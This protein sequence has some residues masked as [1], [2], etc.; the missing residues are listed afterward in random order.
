MSFLEPWILLGLA[1]GLFQALRVAGQRALA[2]RT[3]AQVQL[4][5]WSAALAR[6][7]FGLP[8][9]VLILV[10]LI[11]IWGPPVGFSGL[12]P[13]AHPGPNPNLSLDPGL[14]S[15]R[16]LG[17]PTD[18]WLWTLGAALLQI[19]ATLQ[20]TLLLSQ[21]TFAIGVVYVKTEVVIVALV[22]STPFFAQYLSGLQWAAVLVSVIG[23]VVLTRARLPGEIG[24]VWDLRS[25]WLGLSGGALLAGTSLTLREAGLI[26]VAEGVVVAQP[27]SPAVAGMTTLV[28]LL[29]IQCIVVIGVM[30]L[31]DASEFA[32]V[33]RR[34]PPMAF[35][36]F[37]SALGSAGWFIG[38]V[39]AAPALVKS[40]GQV[41]F[42]AA[43]VLTFVFF[44]ERP[45][46]TEW[47]GMGI[48]LISILMLLLSTL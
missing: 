28:A 31:R 16:L 1:A 42:I 9:A 22:G 2:Q 48:I 27:V 24:S 15:V 12:G 35:T 5:A 11:A 17:L 44:R 21:R 4:S 23:V 30:A 43:I 7:L 19:A 41:E 29:V 8:W 37:L 25:A 3:D 18:F 13:G 46:R 36:G 33:M 10:V 45:S 34:L 32:R 38:Y 47:V 40:V 39:M 26:L 14:R 20:Q 6:C